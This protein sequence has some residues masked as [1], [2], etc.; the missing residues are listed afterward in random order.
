MNQES[1]ALLLLKFCLTIL[2]TA[3]LIHSDQPLFL[4]DS[5]LRFSPSFLPYGTEIRSCDLDC[6]LL[7][8]SIT[9]PVTLDLSDSFTSS[10]K[11]RHLEQ[12]IGILEGAIA[13]LS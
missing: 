7:Q 11:A 4:N 13:T 6:T 2:F 5:L 9:A 12:A 1:V 8:I 10:I 3:L